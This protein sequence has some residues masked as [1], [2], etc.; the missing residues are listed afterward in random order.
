[1][2]YFQVSRFK[3]AINDEPESIII[4]KAPNFFV[5]QLTESDYSHFQTLNA[6][7]TQSSPSLNFLIRNFV[8]FL[9]D[10]RCV[11]FTLISRFV[12]QLNYKI[13]TN[14]VLLNKE[15]SYGYNS[16]ILKIFIFCFLTFFYYD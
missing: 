14:W 6:S 10:F 16:R 7:N 8:L 3:V 4:F 11:Y 15:F 9:N 2:P 5:N 12:M 13:L 1:M